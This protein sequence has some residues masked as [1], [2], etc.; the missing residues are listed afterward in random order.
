M[1]LSP[2]IPL[3]QS[4]IGS[5]QDVS[6]CVSA[7][8]SFAQDLVR[9]TMGCGNLDRVDQLGISRVSQIESAHDIGDWTKKNWG[10][11]TDLVEV[12]VHQ[13]IFRKIGIGGS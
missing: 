5:G 3:S 10:D 13:G 7:S 4:T 6:S 11:W 12:G 9:P 8:V 2:S 1:S